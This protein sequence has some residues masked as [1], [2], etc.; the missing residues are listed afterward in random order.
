MNATTAHCT[1]SAIR[2]PPGHADPCPFTTLFRSAFLTA[3]GVSA[4]Y[5]RAAGETVAGG[6]YLITATLSATVAN[7]LANYNITNTGAG[8][9]IK[10]GKA[11]V[12]TQVTVATHR[13]GDAR[14]LTTGS[15]PAFLTADGVSAT[16]SR[17]AGETV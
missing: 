8:F 2:K 16:Y 9:T 6:P 4:T 7:A 14:P 3:D 13:K 1:T 5:S 11:N 17:A 12:S 10:T 15:G